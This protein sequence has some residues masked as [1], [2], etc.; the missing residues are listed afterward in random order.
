MICVLF[1]VI[2]QKIVVAQRK[3]FTVSSKTSKQKIQRHDVIIREDDPT[4]FRLMRLMIGNGKHLGSERVQIPRAKAVYLARMENTESRLVKTGKRND[5]DGSC[6][7]VV[8]C[9]WQHVAP[10]KNQHFW[11]SRTI[12]PFRVKTTRSVPRTSSR[13]MKRAIACNN[14]K[15]ISLLRI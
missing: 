6:R 2:W 10:A 8:G 12:S 5:V 3:R 4:V 7:F 15:N 14:L 1:K 11:Q 13:T 9:K